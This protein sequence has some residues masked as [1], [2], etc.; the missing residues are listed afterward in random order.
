MRAHVILSKQTSM[1][2][3]LPASGA[4]LNEVSGDLVRPVICAA[5]LVVLAKQLLQ[6]RL[7][8]GVTVGLATASA[9]RSLRSRRAMPGFSPRFHR[10]ASPSRRLPRSA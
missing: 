7:F 1:D 9:M 4:V 2:F 10:R 3:P 8:V 5:D 6:Q